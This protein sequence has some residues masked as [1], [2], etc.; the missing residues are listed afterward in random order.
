[1]SF[2]IKECFIKNTKIQ[3][4]VL[5]R[6]AIILYITFTLNYMY[7]IGVCNLTK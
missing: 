2:I 5:L 1:M 4:I 6:Q 7:D 3:F